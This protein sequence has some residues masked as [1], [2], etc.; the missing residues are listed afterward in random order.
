MPD[1]DY[2]HIKERVNARFKRRLWFIGHVFLFIA[3]ILVVI[4]FLRI[5]LFLRFGPIIFAIWAMFVALHA[6]VYYILDERDRAVDREVEK[7]KRY[8]DDDPL[9][10]AKPIDDADLGHYEIGDD[11]ELLYGNDDEDAQRGSR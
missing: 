1:I 8:L 4:F 7:A 9:H 10:E 5:P 2:E 6:V 3:T 11:G